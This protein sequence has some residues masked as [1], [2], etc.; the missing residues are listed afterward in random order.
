[1]YRGNSSNYLKLLPPLPLGS[2]TSDI[3]VGFFSF[4]LNCCNL[5]TTFLPRYGTFL[6]KHPVKSRIQ[7]KT[8]TLPA[9]CMF[10]AH[11]FL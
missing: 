7:V 9:L 8:F 1:M 2:S 4:F 3:Q 11:L 5:A 10:G 6:V